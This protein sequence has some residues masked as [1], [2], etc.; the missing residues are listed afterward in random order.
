VRYAALLLPPSMFMATVITGNH[1]F[2][3]GVAGATLACA[4]FV[5]AYWL[6]HNWGSVQGRALAF[7]GVSS[8]DPRRN[9]RA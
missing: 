9:P 7:V 4:A 1:F 6:Y 5:T 3:D 8:I 2:V